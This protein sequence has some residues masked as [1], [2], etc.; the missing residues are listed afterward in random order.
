MSDEYDEY[1][2]SE[3]SEEQLAQMEAALGA[4]QG[5]PTITVEVE[6]AADTD[7]K[8]A[9]TDGP[10]RGAENAPTHED[11]ANKSPF[12]RYRW[13]RNAFSVTDLTAPVWYVAFVLSPAHMLSPLLS[14]RCEVQFDYGLRQK[15]NRKLDDRPKSFVTSA[16]KEIVVE[17]AVAARN[18][19]TLKRGQ[20]R[21][22]VQAWGHWR[23]TTAISI[24]GAQ[25]T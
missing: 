15:R 12:E 10:T 11:A 18:D 3:F 17:Q 23:Y 25:E 20:V 19:K 5:G 1:D 8:G 13:K 14:R 21:I 16:G 2:L 7:M 24:D 22:Y 6:D 9:A 4:S